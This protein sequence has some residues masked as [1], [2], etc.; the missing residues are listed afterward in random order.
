MAL[1]ETSIP[2]VTE[3]SRKLRI[4]EDTIGKPTNDEQA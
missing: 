2:N 4:E 1:P 3:G